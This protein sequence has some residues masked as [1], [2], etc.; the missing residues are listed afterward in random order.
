M[1]CIFW[2]QG[3]NDANNLAAANAYQ[4]NLTQFIADT[5]QL[6]GT[7]TD[8]SALPFVIGKLNPKIVYPEA[9]VSAVRAA[10]TAVAASDSRV[11]I[12]DFDDL[13]IQADDLH[14][15][16]SALLEA[17]R[18]LDKAFGAVSGANPEVDNS[19]SQEFTVA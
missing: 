11:A 13:P 4:A 9:S 5:R 17:G 15:T 6:F 3:E 16:G 14:Y 7:R 19:A 12:A 18:R 10:Q 2:V 8:L 1:R